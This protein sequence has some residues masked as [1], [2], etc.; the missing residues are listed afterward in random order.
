MWTNLVAD[1]ADEID[2]EDEVD[3]LTLDCNDTERDDRA[4]DNDEILPD[5]LVGG[6]RSACWK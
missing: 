2:N 3:D 5:A 6:G 4:E 1:F